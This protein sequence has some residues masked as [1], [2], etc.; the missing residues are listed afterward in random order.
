[1]SDERSSHGGGFQGWRN[2]SRPSKSI[3]AYLVSCLIQIVYS[4]IG[5]AASDGRRMRDRSCDGFCD[6]GKRR[7]AGRIGGCYNAATQ[8]GTP[9]IVQHCPCGWLMAVTA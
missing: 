1:M 4:M 2:C 7:L 5:A 3:L 6:P 9:G 8:C